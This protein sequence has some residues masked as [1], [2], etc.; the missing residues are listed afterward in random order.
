MNTLKYCTRAFTAKIGNMGWKDIQ[1]FGICKVIV[2][3]LT[4][5]ILLK[6]EYFMF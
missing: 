4:P 6:I 2:R 5:E 1:A 3:L